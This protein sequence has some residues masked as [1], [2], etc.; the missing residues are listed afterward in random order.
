M[1]EEQ[2]ESISFASLDDLLEKL[3]R[4]YG[5]DKT[6]SILL[7]SLKTENP[8]EKNDNIVV[9]FIVNSA[10]DKFKVSYKKF[11]KT[12]TTDYKR[13]KA[14]CF[15]LIK[16]YTGYSH[17]DIKEYFGKESATI[18][19]IRYAINKIKDLL[20]QP[21]IDK[22]HYNIHIQLQKEV[23]QFISKS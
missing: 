14:S 5:K 4:K 16:K 18:Q 7:Y 6:Y 2:Q 10:I 9:N 21:K 20:E 19:P 1:P 23:E 17:K 8:L 15:Y 3:I 13:C 11:K 12:N 22:H